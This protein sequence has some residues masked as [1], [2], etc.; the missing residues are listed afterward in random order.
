MKINK[1]LGLRIRFLRKENNL[2]LEQLSFKSGINKNYLGDLERGS[3][4]P[5]LQILEK[6][7]NSFNIDLE[8]LFKGIK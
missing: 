5:T 4:N 2:T 8:T 6:I 1:I 7:A 3:R